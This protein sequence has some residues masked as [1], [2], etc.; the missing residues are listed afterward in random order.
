MNRALYY[1]WHQVTPKCPFGLIFV[2]FFGNFLE[3][4]WNFQQIIKNSHRQNYKNH[5]KF[6][7]QGTKAVSEFAM[8]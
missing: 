5:K 4:S 1:N 6:D 8:S 7:W 3:I 2:V